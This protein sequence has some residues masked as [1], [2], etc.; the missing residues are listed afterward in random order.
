MNMKKITII[1]FLFITCLITSVSKAQFIFSPTT[2]LPVDLKNGTTWT[3]VNGCASPGTKGQIAF[4]VTGLPSPLSSS[5]TISEIRVVFDGTCGGN[6]QVTKLIL[7]Y[8]KAGQTPICYIFFDGTNCSSNLSAFNDISVNLRDNPSCGATLDFPWIG[9]TSTPFGGATATW[10]DVDKTTTS[11]AGYYKAGCGVCSSQTSSQTLS[12]TFNGIDPNG[13]WK[14][15]AQYTG[16]ESGQENAPCVKNV[17]L[18]FGNPAVADR[19]TDGE[20]CS[21]PILYTGTPF[22][23]RTTGKTG[24]VQMPG[25]VVA[26]PSNSFGT[27]NGQNCGWNGANNNDVWIKIT[28]TGKYQCISISGLDETLQSIVVTDSKADGDNNPCTQAA[29]TNCFSPCVS[30]DPNW[31]VVSCPRTSSSIYST[32]AGTIKNQQHCFTAALGVDYYL[33][34]DGTGGNITPFYVSGINGPAQATLNNNI[35]QLYGTI[36]SSGNSLQWASNISNEFV[37][38][39]E[40]ERSFNN[41]NYHTLHTRSLNILAQN[42]YVYLDQLPLAGNNYYRVKVVMNDGTYMYS[43]VVLLKG[44]SNHSVT[45]FPNPV[46]NSLNVSSSVKIQSVNIFNAHGQLVYSENLPSLLSFQISTQS[47]AK[48][49]YI[50]VITDPAGNTERIKILK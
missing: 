37:V 11:T 43:A 45:A 48:G 18:V 1:K 9:S 7:R 25:S 35:L 40:L 17:Q 21:N 2:T 38:S 14:I 19:T 6:L 49:Q 22:C 8:E 4:N 33:V 34:V 39:Y 3:A 5:F 50:L 28:G 12:G 15:Y 16:I 32:T 27:I 20:S 24:S 10:T 30:N 47:W 42:E 31:N 26:P 44:K 36:H 23:A 41:Q 46:L 29:K 13:T